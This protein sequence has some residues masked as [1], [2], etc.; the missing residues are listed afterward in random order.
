M[1]M[2]PAWNFL[3]ML[4]KVFFFLHRDL[5]NFNDGPVLC[6]SPSPTGHAKTWQTKI[7]KSFAT[8]RRLYSFRSSVTRFFNHESLTL[9][10][11][12]KIWWNQKNHTVRSY[13]FFF[14]FLSS[15]HRIPEMVSTGSSYEN[16]RR[17]WNLLFT[18]SLAACNS[19]KIPLLKSYA[20]RPS[21]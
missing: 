15:F 5:H 17:D 18:T 10:T 6:S 21:L 1:K 12:Y 19:L 4:E 13:L 3:A 14:N 20:R 7:S 9:L 2:T 16:A 11:I 8:S